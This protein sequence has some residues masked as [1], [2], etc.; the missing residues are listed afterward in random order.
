VSQGR[1]LIAGS[2]LASVA[3]IVTFLVLGG[4]SYAPAQVR[5]PCKTRQWRAPE[6]VQQD[7]EQFSLSALDGAACELHVSRETLVLALGS[8]EGRERFAQDPRLQS[9]VRAGLLRAIDDAERAGALDPLVA[10][11]L[12]VLARQ[13]PVDDVIAL[14]E[15]AKP[16]FERLG[17][18][19]EGARALLPDELQGLIP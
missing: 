15:D 16:V 9:A 17:P 2:L 8:A 10:N 14:I 11:G 13:A 7:V 3:L 18:L 19:L 6:G 12:R 5:D 1:T 4:S